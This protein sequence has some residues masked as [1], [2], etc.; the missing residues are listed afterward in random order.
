M[1]AS[2]LTW[3]WQG[4]ALTL[5]MSAALRLLPR[6]NAAT[7]YWMW[8]CT[9]GAVGALGWVSDTTGLKSCA[10]GGT[11]LSRVRLARPNRFSCFMFQRRRT[12]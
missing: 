9:L 10:T 12:R 7:R 11:G 5:A 2:G 6:L 1:T 8:W 3:L 4:I